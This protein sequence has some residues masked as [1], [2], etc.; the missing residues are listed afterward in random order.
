MKRHFALRRRPAC[1]RHCPLVITLLLVA[2]L[3]IS[4]GTASAQAS[5]K[6]RATADQ[7]TLSLM[8]LHRQYQTASPASRQMLALQLHRA[9]AKRQQF[10]T[11][12]MQSNPGEILRV[13]IP[14]EVSAL[15]PPSVQALVEKHLQ[16]QGELEL[17]VED[18]K[19]TARLHHYLKTSNGKLELQFANHRPA[20]L[21]TGSIIRASGVQLGNA[22]ALACC[23]DSNTNSGT[24]QVL[25]GAQFSGTFGAQSTLVM[26]VNFQD[27]TSQ[28]FSVSDVSTTL[29]GAGN[30]ATNWDL[31]NSLQQAWLTGTVVGWYT[32][33]LNASS[34]PDNNTIATDAN[35]AATAAGINLSNYTHYMYAF[36]FLS[37]CYGW[38]GL[39]TVGGN[40][41]EVWI[42]GQP[43]LKIVTHEMGHNF[44]L[45][46]SHSLS[47]GSTRTLCSDPTISEYGD[48]IDTMGNPSY[49][50]FS[51][52]QKERLGWLNY[53]SSPPITLVQ[54]S[55][56]YT[57][58]PYE[59]QD[60]TP[61][62]L[63][64]LKSTDP[65]SGAKTWY[66][67][68]SRQAVGFDSFLSND[69]NVLNG[70]LVHIG[71]DNDGNSNDLLNMAPSL[72]NFYYSALD[73]G[74]TFI[75][76]D[77][78]VTMQTLSADTT[79]ATVSVTFGTPTCQ[80]FNPTISISPDQSQ[81]VAAGTTVTYT[82]S[83]LN[84][85]NAGCSATTFN[86]TDAIPPGWSASYGSNSL[87]LAYGTSGSSP[88]QVT[89]PNNASTGTYTF[90]VTATNSVVPSL[91]A[92]TTANYNLN[93]APCIHAN[94]TVSFSP[95]TQTVQAGTAALYVLGVTNND[96]ASCNSSTFTLNDSVPGGWTAILGIPSLTISPGRNASTSLQVTSPGDAPAGTYSVAGSATS[97]TDSSLTGS[98]A[99][100]Y[101]IPGACTR[102]NPTVSMSPSQS[103]P[104]SPGTPVNFTVNV[105]DNDNSACPT[106]NF[107]LIANL[108]NGWTGTWSNSTLSLSPGG[109]G[110]ATLTVTSPSTAAN[111][112]YT[113]GAT[114]TD[115]SATSYYGSANATYVISTPSTTISITTNSGTY[116]AGQTVGFTVTVTSGGNPV[117][118]TGVY[119]AI[120]S[121][122]GN[123]TTI[124]GTTGKNGVASLSYTL[125]RQAPTGTYQAQAGLGGKGKGASGPTASTSFSVQ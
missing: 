85:D 56:S 6:A 88:I 84:N 42:N 104:V 61:K 86:L 55:G 27:N 78:G 95:V 14:A 41:A 114:A 80:H 58:G 40:P 91:N 98:A 93:T 53:G 94:P 83:V 39:A 49:G 87:T 9:A 10:L 123:T 15:M 35:A 75:D 115:A 76:P 60:T 5:P 111:G 19:D 112:S 33:P 63:K 89:S 50:H 116:Q 36:P 57:I 24:F 23:N 73:A 29:F 17:L 30:S 64:I 51:A 74:Q 67:V 69:P 54:S 2:S 22:L 59:N 37:N 118:G 25:Q 125:K 79:G 102:A 7:L 26:L 28:P 81:T 65:N 4:A 107:N 16:T 96:N 71:T 47:C 122:N 82:V 43:T 20:N 110:S 121:P 11:S 3:L 31:E 52:F 38:L 108:L 13:A 103:P 62:A 92:S 120:T 1:D 113:V 90:T 124:S 117:A 97:T 21:V 44:G 106:T 68:Q 109:S 46:H 70:V 8:D 101:V 105:T 66:Y 48:V 34:C 12:L 119:V 72:N 77:A 45:Y 100:S 99:A 18:Q 32:L